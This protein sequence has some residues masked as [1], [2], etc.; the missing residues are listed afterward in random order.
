MTIALGFQTD[1]T[2]FVLAFSIQPYRPSIL[3]GVILALLLALGGLAADVMLFPAGPVGSLAV[4]P[5][6][7]AA[8][9]VLGLLALEVRSYEKH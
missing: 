2:R 4:W 6:T 5:A 1:L 9:I 8:G 7:I 3:L